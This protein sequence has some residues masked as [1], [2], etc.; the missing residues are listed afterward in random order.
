MRIFSLLGRGMNLATLVLVALSFFAC[1]ATVAFG[2]AGQQRQET[3]YLER[4]PIQDAAMFAEAPVGS[5]MIVIGTL[6]RNET[7]HYSGLVAYALERW[8]VEY[9]SEDGYQGDWETLE[10]VWPSLLVQTPN[11]W[12]RTAA[13]SSAKFG[14]ETDSQVVR[15]SDSST[16]ASG[17]PEGTIR[18]VGYKNGAALLVVGRKS[19]ADLLVPTRFY[20]G[21]RGALIQE[22][23]QAN[24]FTTCFGAAFM[25]AS[26]LI[27]AAGLWQ[28]LFGR[29]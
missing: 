27:V 21:T 16:R 3:R 17:I 2:F 7:R 22:L 19:D 13:T 6:D 25:L 9:D 23:Q 29:N 1:G 4:L 14:G 24:R 26:V 20:G 12:L 11:G 15:D 8:D 10:Q 28:L 5:E 18:V